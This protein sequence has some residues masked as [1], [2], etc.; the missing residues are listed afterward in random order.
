MGL[1]ITLAAATL[2]I[3]QTLLNYDLHMQM[4]QNQQIDQ[5]L[6]EIL[7]GFCWSN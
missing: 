1:C 3:K 4:I 7:P 5:Q 6:A 2:V